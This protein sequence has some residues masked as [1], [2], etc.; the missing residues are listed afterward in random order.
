MF[1][2]YSY[3]V[4]Q[5]GKLFRNPYS[6]P[7][8]LI[9]SNTYSITQLLTKILNVSCS[10]WDVDFEKSFLYFINTSKM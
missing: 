1:E 6:V 7:V 4:S 8:Q 5:G 3:V 10:I 2:S 9:L